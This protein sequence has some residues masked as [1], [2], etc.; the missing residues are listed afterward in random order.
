[1]FWSLEFHVALRMLETFLRVN[2]STPD[3][4]ISILLL[5]RPLLSE[6]WKM[7]HGNS[8]KLYLQSFQKGSRNQEPGNSSVGNSPF[9]LLFRSAPRRKSEHGMS[10]AYLPREISFENVFVRPADQNGLMC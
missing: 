3:V 7:E 6:R 10:L 9:Y 8:S 1:M 2:R 5:S 4:L